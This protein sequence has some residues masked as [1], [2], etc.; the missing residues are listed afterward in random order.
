MYRIIAALLLVQILSTNKNVAQPLAVTKAA[1]GYTLVTNKAVY[2]P[3]EP[4]KFSINKFPAAAFVRYYHLNELI[5]EEKLS[6]R[7]WTWLPPAAD[8]KGYLVEVFSKQKGKEKIQ[9]VI[10]VDVS[11]SW[12][13]FP[14]YGFLSDFGNKKNEAMD[15]VMA[16]LN[17]NHING[18]QFYDW[19]DKHQQ[20]LAG[21][22]ASPAGQWTDIAGRNSYK[23]TVQGYI[24]KA[25]QLGMQAMFYNL[26]Y[27]AL[28]DA[29][30]DGVMPQ[31][32]MYDDSSHTNRNTFALPK[33][34]FKSDIY[35]TDPSNS[36]WQQYLVKKNSDVYGIYDFDGY[37][38]DQVGE[39]GRVYNYNGDTIDLAATFNPFLAA[40]KAAH[41]HKKIVMNAVNQYG[42]QGSIATAPV[43]FLYSELWTGNEGY[44]ELA[45]AIQNNYEWSNGKG[46]VLAA[47]LN[48]DKAGK[49]GLFNTPGVLL[50]NAVI[51][52]FGGSHLELGEHMLA[53]EYFPNN[54]LRMTED[55]KLSITRYYDFLTAYENLLRDGGV[56]NTVTA[57]CTNGK[58]SVGV[59]PP[60][61]GK[62]AVQGKMI[63]S[64]Q[65]LHFINFANA[66]HFNWR[67]TDG[68]QTIPISIKSADIEVAYTRTATNVWL[69]SPDINGGK[70]ESLSFT[71]TG[72][73]IK[74]TLP[75]LK[76]WD[77]LV[78]E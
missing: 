16:F 51:F 18:L 7:T 33:P 56:F 78:I 53:K 40:M 55:L 43:D 1:P 67:D 20:P 2:K 58:M 42:Q 37:H 44:K 5:K 47:Y 66:S 15:E 9:A 36:E 75:Q 4:V 49:S 68:K 72:N 64:K 38:V 12:D 29:V 27:G 26:C 54:N 3:G 24:N 19:Q 17:R 62:V 60:Q 10:A 61:N 57:N 65:I 77:M 13:R 70:P 71:Q 22:L 41:P 63:G 34:P 45:T 21:T 35:F 28:S 30:A 46:T 11:S 73:V 31:W 8:Y 59:W 32:Y 69:A 74:F 52:A 76:Y 25:H 50:A 14:R 48:Y 39:R 6:G 23:A